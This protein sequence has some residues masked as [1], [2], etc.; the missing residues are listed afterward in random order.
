MSVWKRALTYSVS[1]SQSVSQSVRLPARRSHNKRNHIPAVRKTAA[2]LQTNNPN[3]YKSPT[4]SSC[5]AKIAHYQ[6]GRESRKNSI[7]TKLD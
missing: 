3:R 6:S 7:D 4:K 1:G 5:F 2:M